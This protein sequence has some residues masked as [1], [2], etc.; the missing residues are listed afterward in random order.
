MPVSSNLSTTKRVGR[1]RR[2]PPFC[3][4]PSVF[5]LLSPTFCL[6]S[7]VLLLLIAASTAAADSAG[8]ATLRGQVVDVS[9]QAVARAV[10]VAR[11][12]AGHTNETL[13]D[14]GG[15]FEWT[16]LEAGTYE[17]Q[18]FFEGFR[19]DITPITVTAGAVRE[20]T[21]VLRPAAI[22]ETLVVSASYVETPLSRAP[23]S[24]TI[25]TGGDLQARQFVTAA[26]ALAMA[27]GA[28]VTPSGGPGG[29]TS[30]FSRGGE[31][32]FTL[33]MVDGIKL[34]G[35]GGGFDFGHLTTA[36][37]DRLEQ[38][39]GPQSALAGADAIGGV[40]HLR[41]AL[42]G[43]P[44]VTASFETG[45]YGTNRSVVGTTGSAGTVSWG[46]HLDR[47]TSA[48]W[49]DEAPGSNA[50]VANDDYA[51]TNLAIAATWQAGAR[52]ALRADVRTG[53]NERGYP[54]PF[55]TNPIGAYPGIDLV[56][57][58]TNHLAVGSLSLTHEW[59]AETA[60]RVQGTWGDQRADFVSPWG[61]SLGRTQRLTGLVQF[62]R[63]LSPSLAVSAGIDTHAE[64]ADSTYVV[65]LD[66]QRTPIRR[67]S[68][69]YFG[70]LR[71]RRQDRLFVT[72][73]LRIENIRR[74][75][76]DADPSGFPPRP[77]LAAEHVLSPNPRL[78]FTH[79]LRTSNDSGGNW[80]RIHAAAG[81]GIR[82]PDPFEIAFTDNAALK[83]ERSRS[84]DAGIEQA[85]GGGL[86]VVG[87]T[88]FFNRYDD[89][90]V[91][92][93][94]DLGGFSRYRT[95]NISN[96]R[97]RGL[98]LTTSLRLRR[99]FDVRVSYTWLDTE[100]LAVDDSDGVAPP[101]FRVGD[102]LIRRPR[103][104]AS[105]DLLWTHGPLTAFFRAGGRGSVL[106]VEPNWGAFGGLFTAPG[107]VVADAGCAWRLGR[108][109][110]L[111]VRSENLFDREYEAAFGYPAPRRAFMVGVRVAAGR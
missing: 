107:F 109:L 44:S 101:P 82:V 20:A 11:S 48:G 100:V 83:P 85:L 4:L 54:G 88:T 63:A 19:G 29:V 84:V 57:R 21:L 41:T 103:H 91:A 65:G 110:E 35:F 77:A 96:A 23:G 111:L 5:C 13:T 15:R 58:G 92:I 69:G 22:T 12:A 47:W 60:F 67:R 102:P 76:L 49:T 45:G 37:L 104:Q 87:A 72:G 61:S 7:P 78:A 46:A 56:S 24:I 55:G 68:L 64:Q 26:A 70:E 43:R 40:I 106:D 27:P 86:V 18:A 8:A 99:A 51:A 32:D 17:V 2:R 38:A 98:E 97:S 14:G 36:G 93:G 10:V 1:S 53:T 33:V 34:N 73:G 81:T 108:S 9:G 16:T 39:R 31:S 3:L 75:A 90:I 95:D 52:T 6:L 30:L 80:S 59:N 25:M 42:G 94:G 79:Y 28:I 50:V 74:S 66:G 105:V 62:D 89:L 71:F